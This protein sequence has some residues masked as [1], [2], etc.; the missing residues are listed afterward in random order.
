MSIFDMICVA[1]LAVFCGGF[2]WAKIA[3]LM[4]PPKDDE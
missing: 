3:R 4:T 2:I 1:M